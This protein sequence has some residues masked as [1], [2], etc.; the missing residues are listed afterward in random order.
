MTNSA[1]KARNFVDWEFGWDNNGKL[2]FATF[3][4]F[5]TGLFIPLLI[6]AVG[7][8]LFLNF[9]LQSLNSENE[10]SQTANHKPQIRTLLLFCLPFVLCFI[11]PNVV[12]LAPWVW[13]NIK[14]LVYWFVI[15]I[16]L[17]AWLLAQFWEYGQTGKIVTAAL[18]I[19]LMLSGW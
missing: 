19:V 17:V 6:F 18:L 3:W 12:R 4:I 8:L 7:F 16:P 13:D 1:S 15:S 14:V 5:N 11:V 9:K 2:S 10:Q